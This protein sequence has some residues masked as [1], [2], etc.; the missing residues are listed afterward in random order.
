MSLLPALLLAAFARAQDPAPY[1]LPI[2][3]PSSETLRAQ[4]PPLPP[5]KQA[6][7][8]ELQERGIVDK[9]LREWEP[10]DM[11]LL[12]RIQ[13][14]ERLRAFDMLQSRAGTLRGYAINKRLPDGTRVLWLTKAGFERYF[15]LKSQQARQYFE[16]KG[17][18]AKWVYRMRNVK[19]KKLFDVSGMLTPEGD[20]LYT[21]VLLGLP[22]EW[23]GGDGVTRSNVRPKKPSPAPSPAPAK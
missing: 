13:E 10:G 9:N 12:L 18:D 22:A 11:Q 17:T 4:Q 23:V 6:M 20:A 8:S 21:R 7:L 16:V 15:F 14:A 5:D 1:D 2:P 19:G 3:A